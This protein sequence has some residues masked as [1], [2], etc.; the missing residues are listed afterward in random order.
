MLGCQAPCLLT[1]LLKLRFYHICKKRFVSA[2]SMAHAVL[3]RDHSV[4]PLDNK[5]VDAR[6]CKNLVEAEK[7]SRLKPIKKNEPG[8]LELISSIVCM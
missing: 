7:R 8:S 2:V 3:K 6:I 4:L 1:A 5:P